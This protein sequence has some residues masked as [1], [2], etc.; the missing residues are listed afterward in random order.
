M[1]ITRGDIYIIFKILLIPTI[2]SILVVTIFC[3]MSYLLMKEGQYGFKIGFPFKFYE[4]FKTS[5]GGVWWWTP[6]NLILDL[7]LTWTLSVWGYFIWLN[8]FYKPKRK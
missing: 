2:I 6:I 1:A 8:K 5:D 7:M 4:E 3:L